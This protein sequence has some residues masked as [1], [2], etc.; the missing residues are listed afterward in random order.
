MLVYS[1][2]PFNKILQYYIE[3]FWILQ[4][5]PSPA[6][7]QP[8]L[9]PKTNF[10]L[11][12]SFAAPTVW[13]NPGGKRQMLKSSFLCGLRKEPII[14]D[15]QGDVD[16]LAVTFR[17]HGLYPF[18][19][20]PLSEIVNQSIDLELLASEFSKYLTEQLFE[21][22]NPNR[23]IE[24]LEKVL[25]DMLNRNNVRMSPILV[26]CLRHIQTSQ[27]L[28]P[29]KKLCHTFNIHSKKLERE[30]QK[31]VGVS[32]K[33]YSKQVKM[34]AILNHILEHRQNVD[35]AELACRFDFF[36]QPHFIKAFKAFIGMTPQNFTENGFTTSDVGRDFCETDF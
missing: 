8:I 36:D 25:L 20:F 10:D 17:P 28:I 11:I 31:W 33:F 3:E 14:I 26:Q 29:I 15:A 30:F 19:G 16:Y 4:A 12:L 21:E 23:K 34:N 13:E 9:P 2:K 18:L 6:T 24:L 35:W 22:R 32:P 5:E 27:G 7:M 1:I